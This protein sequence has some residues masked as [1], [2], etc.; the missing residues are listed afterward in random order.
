MIVASG[1]MISAKHAKDA[2]STVPILF[3][4]ADDPVAHGFV[5]SLSHPGGNATGVSL[6]TIDTAQQRSRKMS[7]ALTSVEALPPE[8]AAQ[9]LPSTRED[10]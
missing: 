10:R 8:E 1:G 3:I 5:Q 9:L 4:A 2:T 7:R 6:N